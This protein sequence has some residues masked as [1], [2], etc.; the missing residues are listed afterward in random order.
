VVTQPGPA[1][2]P[3]A[4]DDGRPESG[5]DRRRRR[6]ADHI[7]QTAIK[8]FAQHGYRHVCI[9]DVATAAGIS[10]RTVAR[11]FP[12]KEDLLLA[13]PR[14]GYK[15]TLDAL[16][17]VGPTAAP[18]AAVW[19]M[20]LNLTDDHKADL[21]DVLLWHKAAATAPEVTARALGEQSLAVQAGLTEFCAE[22][23]DRDSKSDPGPVV[24]AACIAAANRAVVDFWATQQGKVDL[25]EVFATA[26]GTLSAEFSEK[27]L[28]SERPRPAGSPQPVQTRSRRR[29]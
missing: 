9:D 29:R 7:E 19:D 8:L 6:M 5:W 2:P 18:V 17:A 1:A 12:T 4:S 10:S 14:R 3:S 21:K 11:Y 22:A 13:F 27:R 16:K 20:W 25:E 28:H 15:N 26:I 23:L 24:L